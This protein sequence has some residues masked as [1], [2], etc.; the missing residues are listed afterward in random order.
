MGTFIFGNINPHSCYDQPVLSCI[1]PVEYGTYEI[2][3]HCH[4]VWMCGGSLE[5]IPCS[6]VGHIFRSSH[7]Y[8]FPG[9]TLFHVQLRVF[10]LSSPVFYWFPSAFSFFL[11]IILS[12][13]CFI[14]CLP[15]SLTYCS[16]STLSVFIFQVVSNVCFS[17]CHVQVSQV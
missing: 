3:C 13:S 10:S 12:F 2:K 4:Q 14:L 15:Y 5:F 6:R 17:K 9:E 7:P 16:S 8:T 11:L 1:I